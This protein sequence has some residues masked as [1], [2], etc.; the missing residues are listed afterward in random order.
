V[1]TAERQREIARQALAREENIRQQGLRDAREVQQARADVAEAEA[2]SR[3]AAAIALG[4]RRTVQAA[5][6]SRAEA[7]AQRVRA[8]SAAAAALK[9]LQ[10]LGASPEGGSQIAITTPL[11][12]EVEARPVNIGE[13]VAAGQE[14]ASVLNTDTVW[15][16]SDVFERD[17]PN[18]RVGQRVTVAAD[19]VPGRT[20][21]GTVSHIGGEVNPQTRAVRVRTVVSN[22]GEV[23]KPNMFVRVLIAAAGSGEAVTVPLAAVQEDGAGQ[24]V[25]IEESP[26]A[27]RR[28]PVK[29]G[30][31]LGDQV[32]VESGLLP[33]EKVVTHGAYQLVSQVK[34]G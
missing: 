22:R 6:G 13:V 19:A 17:L 3:S 26:G 10:L 16:E 15:V 25:F 8:H 21:G 4:Q 23:L 20:F 28:R 5:E 11:S 18:V 31:T 32:V 34:R 29:L 24:I 30:P 33:G 9:R 7:E 27:Y 1:T 2:A 12:G 14:L